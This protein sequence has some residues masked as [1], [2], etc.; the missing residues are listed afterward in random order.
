MP[1]QQIRQFLLFTFILSVKLPCSVADHF[2]Y[3]DK[4]GKIR[5]AIYGGVDWETEDILKK[6][7]LLLNE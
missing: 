7:T 2:T 4:K 3:F 6:I 5:Y 1:W